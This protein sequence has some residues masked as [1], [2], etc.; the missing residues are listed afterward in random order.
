MFSG[1]GR[2]LR[3]LSGSQTS[4]GCQEDKRTWVY[5]YLLLFLSSPHPELRESCSPLSPLL[6]IRGEDQGF[7]SSSQPVDR[8]RHTGGGGRGRG[9]GS[10]G[11]G[12]FLPTGVGQMVDI[13]S[14]AP[15]PALAPALRLGPGIQGQ[16]LTY[17]PEH[18]LCCSGRF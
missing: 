9:R 6:P 16:C 17:H 3:L 15:L 11:R 2:A 8:G 10:T 4:C 18:R 5:L 13:Q 7:A 14:P 12:K 1:Q